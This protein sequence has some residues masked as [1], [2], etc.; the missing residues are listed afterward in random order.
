MDPLNGVLEFKKKTITSSA[1]SLIPENMYI[2]LSNPDM[3]NAL[4]WRIDTSALEQDKVFT[5]H[6]TEGVLESKDTVCLIVYMNTRHSLILIRE[7]SLK[8]C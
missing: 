6:P 2:N 3:R 7:M 1:D 4:N 8:F 5:L